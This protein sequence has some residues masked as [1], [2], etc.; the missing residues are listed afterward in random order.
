LTPQVTPSRLTQPLEVTVCG[1]VPASC[2][3]SCLVP[4]CY[5]PSWHPPKRSRRGRS[6]GS[7]SSLGLAASTPPVEAF[8][9]GLRE[10]G[11]VEGQNIALEF[12]FAEGRIDRL[13]ALAAELVRLKVGEPDP[14]DAA[15]W[16]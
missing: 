7:E 1:S 15:H 11:Y 13:S 10:H 9:Q 3:P 12:R 16:T 5:S 4:R 6:S 14:T 2:S 8:R